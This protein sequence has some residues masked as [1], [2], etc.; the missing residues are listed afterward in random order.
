LQTSD[1][2]AEKVGDRRVFSYEE[3]D[4]ECP[5]DWIQSDF[6]HDLGPRQK[7]E[8]PGED[9]RFY[10][11]IKVYPNVPGG[12]LD[13]RR[14]EAELVLAGTNAEFEYARVNQVDFLKE[15]LTWSREGGEGRQI[16]LAA[17]ENDK[18]YDIW[19]WV[20]QLSQDDVDLIDS[21]LG[22]VRIR[23]LKS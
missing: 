10:V 11:A 3:V 1:P 9:G 5:A 15:T 7:I 20:D 22:S 23:E 19:A 6:S 12:G 4:I 13:E 8:P 21:I 14:R 17:V 18:R 16:L 2:S